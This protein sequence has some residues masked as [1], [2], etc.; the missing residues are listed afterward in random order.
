[1]DVPVGVRNGI[2]WSDGT[3]LTSTD[4]AYS[5]K[6]AQASFIYASEVAHIAAVLTPSP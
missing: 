3:P 6:A 2:R 1:V 5:L 4:I